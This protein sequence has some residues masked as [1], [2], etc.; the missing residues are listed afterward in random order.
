MLIEDKEGRS[1]LDNYISHGVRSEKRIES[2][3]GRWEEVKWFSR[4]KIS[5]GHLDLGSA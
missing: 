5:S 3:K 2:E 1:D 4:A